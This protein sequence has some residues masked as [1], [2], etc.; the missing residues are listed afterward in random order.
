MKRSNEVR[1]T[2]CVMLVEDDSSLRRVMSLMLR[3]WGC[4]V[5]TCRDGLEALDVLRYVSPD[6]IISDLDMPFISGIELF[7]KYREVA[8]ESEIPFVIISGIP[9]AEKRLKGIRDDLLGFYKKPVSIYILKRIIFEQME[10]R[11]H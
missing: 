4:Q 8:E 1:S 11:A 7:K 3:D 6:L 10:K 2:K 9:D 5:I